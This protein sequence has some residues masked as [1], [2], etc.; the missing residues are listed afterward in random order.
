MTR[1]SQ[2]YKCF[3]L[4]KLC[5]RVPYPIIHETF[6]CV[7]KVG[8]GMSTKQQLIKAALGGY[9]LQGVVDM[10]E[11]FRAIEITNPQLTAPPGATCEGLRTLEK[12]CYNL[13]DKQVCFVLVRHQSALFIAINYRISSTFFSHVNFWMSSFFVCLLSDPVGVMWQS[14]GFISVWNGPHWSGD[15]GV[16]RI[17]CLCWIGTKSSTESFAVTHL[18]AAHRTCLRR[19]PQAVHPLEFGLFPLFYFIW[20]VMMNRVID[21]IKWNVSNF[22]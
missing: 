20:S 10:Q 11:A 1:I 17:S 22:P 6:Q 5:D 13:L 7:L 15:W 18:W 16:H 21:E 19:L 9:F 3:L 4:N 8:F 2:R 14:G 12:I